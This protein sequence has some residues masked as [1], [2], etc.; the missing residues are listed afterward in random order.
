MNAVEI[1]EAVTELVEQ[2]F[3]PEEFPYS[4]LAAFDNPHATIERLKSG[5]TNHSDV[6][7]V[8]QR[9][10]I[11]ILVCDTGSVGAALEKLRESVAT[12]SQKAKFILATDGVDIEAEDLKSGETLACSYTDLDEK[13]GFFLPLA[14]ITTVREIRESSFDI[15]A[16][17]RLN[18]L[19]IELLKH[20]PEWSTAGKRHE[21]N[22]FM[23]RLIF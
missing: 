15:K 10:N 12:T 19:Y 2:P 22:H 9:N 20:N 17:G 1:A 23:A 5:T 7:G 6:A 8:L 16:T 18:K 21:M 4:F 3:K 11:H 14:N 13:F